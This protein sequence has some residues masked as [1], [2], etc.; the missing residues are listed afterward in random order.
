MTIKR[1]KAILANMLD[2]KINP[3]FQ[4]QM[5]KDLT[6]KYVWKYNTNFP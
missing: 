6:C 4:F 5:E 3:G 1:V 2:T